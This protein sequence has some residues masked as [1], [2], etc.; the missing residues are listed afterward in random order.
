MGVDIMVIHIHPLLSKRDVLSLSTV[1]RALFHQ[2]EGVR[3]QNTV[4]RYKRQGEMLMHYLRPEALRTIKH[5]GING[6]DDDLNQILDSPDFTGVTAVTISNP[7]QPDQQEAFRP[8]A[9][10]LT[11]LSEVCF[12]EDPP[13]SSTEYLG[14]GALQNLHTFY[15]QNVGLP[16]L[17]ELLANRNGIAVNL[18]VI[19]F[20][21][22]RVQEVAFTDKHTP[23]GYVFQ[24]IKL[25]RIVGN[26]KFV[27]SLR[28]VQVGLGR[29]SR[30][31]S[32]RSDRIAFFTELWNS[33]GAHGMWRLTTA[34]RL[35]LNGTPFLDGWLCS[36]DRLNGDLFLTAEEVSRFSAW[37]KRDGRYPRFEDFHT[38]NIHITVQPTGHGVDRLDRDLLDQI[39]GVSVL[40]GDLNIEA[41]LSA[42]T[43]STRCVLIQIH[44]QWGTVH[45]YPKAK[46]FAKIETLRIHNVGQRDIVEVF[47]NPRPY[48]DNLP[49][50]I[51]T[52]LSLPKWTSLSELTVPTMALQRADRDDTIES[53][54][55]AATCGRHL[56]AYAFAWLSALTSLRTLQLIDWLA[57]SECFK[58]LHQSEFE[59]GVG[60]SF[61]GELK[62]RIP[63][64]VTFFLLSGTFWCESDEDLWTIALGHEIRNA[65]GNDVSLNLSHLWVQDMEVHGDEEDEDGEDEDDD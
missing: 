26:N 8:I 28:Q 54:P 3:F 12:S 40:P 32:M 19:A 36:C 57:C 59:V 20:I 41:C 44:S 52:R 25:F 14:D 11:E 21:P 45:G 33:A 2:L 9:F 38:D 31:E 5:L 46:S 6:T 63:P 49:L 34:T 56:P 65:V 37:C 58:E 48:N 22:F 50:A 42:V 29:G 7:I 27:P 35:P 10:Q 18:T 60:Y 47:D 64:R 55:I 4:V 17:R 51:L 43:G 16:P 53:G 23:D 15:L 39:R 30:D 62:R 24:A 1:N 13:G 61:L